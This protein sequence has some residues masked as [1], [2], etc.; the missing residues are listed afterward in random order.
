MNEERAISQTTQRRLRIAYLTVDDP[1]DRRSWSG[2]Y[3][4]M[5]RALEKYCGDIVCFG[6]FNPFVRT[7][8]KVIYRLRLITGQSYLHTHT[9]A[10]SRKFGKMAERRMSDK[11]F[12]VVFAP[13]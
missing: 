5:A 13:A 7:V 8:G 12:D 2:I 10:L 3:Y 9:P 4:F 1:N 11:T 6:P